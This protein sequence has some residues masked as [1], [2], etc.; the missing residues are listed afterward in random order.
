MESLPSILP[1]SLAYESPQR[2]VLST[3][4]TVSVKPTSGVNVTGA[5]SQDIIQFRL[6]NTGFLASC[7]LKGT[8][9]HTGVTAGS[10]ASNSFSAS[11]ASLDQFAPGS[12]WIRRY[13]AKSSDGTELTNI[14]AYNRYSSIINRF[15][16]TSEWS[17]S[18][19]SCMEHCPSESN[20]DAVN[21]G[22]NTVVVAE[23]GSTSH[24][25]GAIGVS[26]H[27]FGEVVKRR[28][29]Q[30]ATSNDF[31]HEFL[32]GVLQGGQE[33]MLPLGL[34]GSGMTLELTCEDKD[35]VYRVISKGAGDLLTGGA[36][37]IHP[38]TG[39]GIV[40]YNLTGLELVCDLIFYPPDITSA[41]SAKM[42]SEGLKLVVD[43][44]RQ[45]QNAVTQQNNT[46]ILNS[47]SRSVKSILCGVK[48]S[49]DG[50][51]A[52]RDETEYY[53]NPGAG[54]A[55]QTIQFSVGSELAPANPISFG[56]NSHMELMKALKPF[57]GEGFKYG[58][59]VNSFGYNKTFLA[60]TAGAGAGGAGA[61][62]G[63]ALMG[64]N[65]QSHP[66]MPDVLSGR[67]ASAGSIPISCELQFD[68]STNLSN[69]VLETFVISDTI[70]ELLG[71]G[72]ALVSK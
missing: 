42:C 11:H 67:S 64:I 17:E 41:L 5:S 12:S 69:A 57:V 72:S 36:Y 39:A 71:D 10:D 32:S 27:R 48:N 34:M 9:A 22:F 66:E 19:G 7:Y 15:K 59:Q 33:Q 49:S 65:L 21:V 30:T 18:I 8:I 68:G 20:D 53:K 4:R 3:R 2:A 38:A 40:G 56:A 14:N 62:S 37:D 60:D 25:A 54:S 52:R 1:P 29:G 26:Q 70:I 28:L 35:N 6:P 43:N 58:N 13:V 55:V 61:V 50:G 47:H 16:N 63:S 24:A 45:Q 46:V 51:N 31:V 23:G 44:V